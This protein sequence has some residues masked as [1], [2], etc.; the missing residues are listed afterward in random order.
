MDIPF[1]SSCANYRLVVRFTVA[2]VELLAEP[3]CGE[4]QTHHYV[5]WKAESG[6]S[7][8]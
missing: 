6:S 3:I 8:K 7:G 5:V 1:L 4:D 2:P